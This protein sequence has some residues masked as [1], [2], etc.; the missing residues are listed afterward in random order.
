MTARMRTRFAPAPTG[1]LHLGHVVNAVYVWGLAH[2]L[3]AEVVLRIE[4]HDAQRSRAAFETAILDDLDWLGFSPDRYP[5]AAFR[6][7]PCE[8]RQSERLAFYATTAA[9]MQAR[10]LVYG[11]SCSRQDIAAQH[12]A[13]GHTFAGYPGTC[14]SRGLEPV[15]GLTWRVR[16]DGRAEAFEDLLQGTT[17]GEPASV[18]GDPAIRDRHGNW[19]YTFAVVADDLD[20]AVTLVVRGNDLRHAT[21]GQI[22]LGRMLG[23]AR[24]AAF[25]HHGLVMASPTR[26]LSKADGATGISDL[27]HAGWSSSQVIGHA[28]GLAGLALPGTEVSARDAAA[29]LATIHLA[30]AWP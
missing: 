26:K 5:T 17:A 19:T 7:G 2:R 6:A 27:R 23:R 11:C 24:P 8:S 9:V 22:Q 15:D 28:A 1:L 4:D 20:Q 29:L 13:G 21:P 18:Q 30:S 25:A 16:M 12:A 10:G 3:G 14:R